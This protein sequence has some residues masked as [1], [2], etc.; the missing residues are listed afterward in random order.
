M[1]RENKRTKAKNKGRKD[2][3]KRSIVNFLVRNFKS[4]FSSRQQF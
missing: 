1:T 4:Y 2:S 3:R